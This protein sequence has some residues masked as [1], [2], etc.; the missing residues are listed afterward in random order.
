VKRTFFPKFSDKRIAAFGLSPL[1][2]LPVLAFQNPTLPPE[3]KTVALK[4]LQHQVNLVK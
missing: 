2:Y 4:G 3:E 1:H